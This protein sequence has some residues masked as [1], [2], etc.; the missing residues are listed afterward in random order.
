MKTIM[1]ILLLC[2]TQVFAADDKLK[3]F[4]LGAVTQTTMDE[5]LNDSKKSLVAAGFQLLADYEPFG[6]H[7]VL[8][9]THPKLIAIAKNTERGGYGAVQRIG[10]SAHGDEVEVSYVNPLYLQNAYRLEG[11]MQEIADM[12]AKTLGAS[13]TFGSRKGLTARKLKKYHY[14]ISMPYFDD[15]YQY[16]EFNSYEQAV[17]EV[18]TRLNNPDDGLSL[19]YRLDIP[20][21]QQTIFGVGM[22]QSNP[23]EE[24]IDE[25]A[26]LGVVDFE[27]PSKIAYLPY[28]LLVNGNEAEAL[29]MKFRMAV[30]FPDLPMM[31]KH[32]FTK[33]M[34][35]PGAIDDAFENLIE[36]H[37]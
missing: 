4:V 13:D 7:H 28:E 10:L 22:K 30:H 1:M 5:A 2:S 33:L 14:M 11:D 8:V 37:R 15:P 32:G 26:Q 20:G 16:D 12:L 25:Q 24:D 34:S 3:P 6:G 29:H 17:S 36:G 9:A 18:E 35:S 21:K 27:R 19:I 23:A 31:G